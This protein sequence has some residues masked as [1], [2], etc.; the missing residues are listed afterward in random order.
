MNTYE[1]ESIFPG[2]RGW[3]IFNNEDIIKAMKEMESYIA[4]WDES[5]GQKEKEKNESGPKHI[6][7]GYENS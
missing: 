5:D 4:H 1:H 3:Q 7:P 6:W 2:A